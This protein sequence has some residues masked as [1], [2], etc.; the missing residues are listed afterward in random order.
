MNYHE[1]AE[2]LHALMTPYPM[3]NLAN[4]S[5]VLY[6]RLP[7]LNWAGFYLMQDGKLILGPFQG[8]AACVE[9]ALGRGVCGTAAEQDAVLRVPDV[10]VFPGHIACDSASNAEIVLPLHK[11]GAVIGVLDMDSPVKDRFTEEDEAGLQEIAA[12]LEQAI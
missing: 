11:N 9:I 12:L 7:N 4:A 10:H 1:L 2:E 5:A 3:A 8:K 6:H